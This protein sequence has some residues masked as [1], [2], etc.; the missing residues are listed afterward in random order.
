MDADE[1]ICI[2]DEHSI[3]DEH[4]IDDA[5]GIND[6]HVI[7]DEHSVDE[8]YSEDEYVNWTSFLLYHYSRNTPLSHPKYNRIWKN[9]PYW[10]RAQQQQRRRSR[11]PHRSVEL[12]RE[13]ALAHA[14]NPYP[15]MEDKLQFCVDGV[16]P[17]QVGY[18]FINER[19]RH[20][21]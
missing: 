13:W 16:T 1:A 6:T 5:H 18:W 4:G 19:R 8:P 9:R 7:G 11:L 15:S 17:K 2:D 12:M 20:G 21:C 3:G 10:L 14:D